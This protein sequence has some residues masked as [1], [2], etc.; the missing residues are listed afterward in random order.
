MHKSRGKLVP[1]KQASIV[2]SDVRFGYPCD[3]QASCESLQ[4]LFA[5]NRS[6]VNP[7]PVINVWGD[8]KIPVTP[9]TLGKI[10]EDQRKLLGQPPKH[11]QHFSFI[12]YGTITDIVLQQVELIK[13]GCPFKI[14]A[15]SCDEA[16]DWRPMETIKLHL[17]KAG[18]FVNDAPHKVF[19]KS[20]ILG[21]LG[22]ASPLAMTGMAARDF[23]LIS[24][25]YHSSH[26]AHGAGE[27]AEVV[28]HGLMS[29]KHSSHSKGAHKDD[30][31]EVWMKGKKPSR[32]YN[33]AFRQKY[34]LKL[35][36][37]GHPTT[38]HDAIYDT[39]VV[40]NKEPIDIS[41][42]ILYAL[43]NHMPL[44]PASKA[45]LAALKFNILNAELPSY[46]KYG[47]MLSDV[48]VPLGNEVHH[49]ATILDFFHLTQSRGVL[50]IEDKLQRLMAQE[51]DSLMENIHVNQVAL[52][53]LYN[54]AKAL[55]MHP[56]STHTKKEFISIE[57]ELKF[58]HATAHVEQMLQAQVEE[59][60]TFAYSGDLPNDVTKK[61]TS[62]ADAFDNQVYQQAYQVIYFSIHNRLPQ[63]LTEQ[64]LD[65]FKAY[66]ETGEI[67][68]FL[69][70]GVDPV[71]IAE[72]KNTTT[73]LRGIS[74]NGVGIFSAVRNETELSDDNFVISI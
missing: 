68:S 4:K 26:A 41:L 44:E 23:E 5:K 42:H 17:Y 48:V 19:V 58:V 46:L 3:D 12:F 55:S 64:Q 38:S 35:M 37:H 6:K 71:C 43:L 29:T 15:T 10:S 2:K 27:L 22:P 28:G 25:I 63:P 33:K 54:R 69:E 7:W 51:D 53:K 30:P 16:G 62:D 74:E 50:N 47:E 8:R 66:A 24:H 21:A 18:G 40:T 31:A 56:L 73:S 70:E 52:R 1:K 13:L 39:G 36:V 60:I 11:T 61:A 67:P 32:I 9:I 34:I 49:L 57:C 20:L 72:A 65:V 45:E 59:I 14:F